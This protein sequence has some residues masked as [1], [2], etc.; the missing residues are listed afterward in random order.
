MAVAIQ[1]NG[2]GFPTQYA[3]KV[4]N[5]WSNQQGDNAYVTAAAGD[6]L[7]AVAIGMKS[8]DPFDQLASSHPTLDV[9]YFPGLLDF[10]SIP[11]I[12]DGSVV[13]SPPSVGNN[14]V[15]SAHYSL[16]DADYT[17]G[18][19]PPAG[20]YPA[21]N[22]NLDG[23]FPSIYVWTCVN[24]NSGTYAVNLDSMYDN[25]VSRPDDLAAGKPIFDGGVN[26]FVSKFTWSTGTTTA[27]DET[28]SPPG[29]NESGISSANPAVLNAMTLAGTHDLGVVIGL[30][31]SANG[32]GLGASAGLDTPGYQMFA[33]GK[34]VGSEAHYLAEWAAIT[35]SGL[36]TPQFSNP[37]GYETLMAA[38]ALRRT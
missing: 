31:K 10:N 6:T 5:L 32:L 7:V 34:L 21:A 37:L 13:V 27:V 4:S 18:S 8:T 14:W 28:T 38:V 12:S 9:A 15:L 16:A 36:W 17:V 3:S 23:Y 29:G 2:V 19:V 30:Q 26:F 11:T 22:W 33:S 1:T 35:G 24:A 25:G 20:A